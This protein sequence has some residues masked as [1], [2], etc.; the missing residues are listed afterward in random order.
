[1]RCELTLHK[2]T[3]LPVTLVDTSNAN[4]QDILVLL[5]TIV[6]LMMLVVYIIISSVPAW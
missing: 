5:M 3:E 1:M 6:R 4:N 2:S